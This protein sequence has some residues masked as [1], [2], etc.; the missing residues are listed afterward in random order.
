MFAE[1]INKQFDNAI[2]VSADMH[3]SHRPHF[4]NS[5]DC[6]RHQSQ[7]LTAKDDLTTTI[8]LKIDISLSYITSK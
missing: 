5:I 8:D 4:Q 7:I 3:A 2:P 1:F 6:N